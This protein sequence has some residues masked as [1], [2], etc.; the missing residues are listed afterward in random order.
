MR[1]A[2]FRNLLD[3]PSGLRTSVVSGTVDSMEVKL[4][5]EAIQ[6]FIVAYKE[7]HGEMLSFAEA[8]EMANRVVNFHLFLADILAKKKGDT[9][10][11]T[12]SEFESSPVSDGSAEISQNRLRWV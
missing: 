7:S 9:P 12:S 2:Q 5:A 10:V 6:E 11:P 4:P 3:S 8:E 1:P